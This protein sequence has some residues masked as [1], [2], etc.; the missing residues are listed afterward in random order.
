ML[1]EIFMLRSETAFREK[2]AGAGAYS[3]SDSRFVPIKLPISRIHILN[4]VAA[5][6]HDA[7]DHI[8]RGVLM[9]YSKQ[10]LHNGS[11]KFGLNV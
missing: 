5:V 10:R 3:S 1:A 9:S 11:T 8:C 4:P 7:V 6:W 2:N